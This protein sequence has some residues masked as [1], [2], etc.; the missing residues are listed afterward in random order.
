MN[1]SELVEKIASDADLSKA[2]ADRALSAVI[3]HIM[4]AVTKGDDVQLI[5]F[6]AFKSGKRAARLG[7][8]P[9]TGAEIKIPAAKTVKFTAGKAF[10]DAVNK[11][12]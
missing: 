11:R 2:S 8:N 7:R 6:G 1:K 5:G 10:K 9:A 12:K 3:A 4:K